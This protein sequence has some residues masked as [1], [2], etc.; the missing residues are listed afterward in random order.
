MLESVSVD[1]T[2]II[3][4]IMPDSYGFVIKMWKSPIKA[5]HFVILVVVQDC[6][7]I[8]N[9]AVQDSNVSKF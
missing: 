6:N 7:A 9:S 3:A 5:Y 8:C 2:T 1:D 4:Y